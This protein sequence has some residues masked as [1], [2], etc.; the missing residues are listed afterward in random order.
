MHTY[1]CAYV[2]VCVLCFG[3]TK[4]VI[5]SFPIMGNNSG[6]RIKQTNPTRTGE[7]NSFI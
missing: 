1:I 3:V 4:L 7:V 2:Y 6:K 5:K